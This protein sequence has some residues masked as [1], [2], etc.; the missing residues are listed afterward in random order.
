MKTVLIAGSNGMVGSA[1]FRRLSNEPDVRLITLNRGDLD[2]RSQSDVI[3]FFSKNK[4]DEL[5]I[6]AAKVGGILANK[7]YPAEF[8]Y[9]N[10]QIQLNLIHSAYLAK[11][12]K[13][14][15]LGSSCIYPRNASQPIKEEFLMQGDLEQTNFA[16][17][18]AKICG[19]KMCESYN[20]QYGTDFRSLMPTNLYGP[21]DNFDLNSSHVLPALITKFH[22]AK[23]DSKDSVIVWGSGLPRR[24]FLHVDDLADAAVFIMGLPREEI[25]NITS[26]Y[27]SHLNVGVGVD[28][29]ISEL[30]SLIASTTSFSGKIIFDK[31]M[32]DG[33][34]Q[35]LLDI[36]RIKSLGWQHKINLSDGIEMTYKWYVDNF[37]DVSGAIN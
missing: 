15:F 8:I 20:I 29:T 28:I 14:I 25:E 34:P 30:A 26:P 16:Y 9:D 17:A 22:Q 32:P 35:K 37:L 11:I 4:I 23:R 21:N 31:S 13:V 18:I 12:K 24:E 1:I 33:T 6:A 2:L 3:N 19:I 10:T 7:N 27:L 36:S 5:Y